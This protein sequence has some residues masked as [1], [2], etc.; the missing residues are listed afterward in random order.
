MRWPLQIPTV[1][2]PILSPLMRIALRR[3]LSRLVFFPFLTGKRPII[4][5]D[6]RGVGTLQLH[7]DEV[8]YSTLDG[9]VW[10]RNGRD[11]VVDLRV[12]L[13]YEHVSSMIPG[14]TRYLT[15]GMVR[16]PQ[17]VR[18]PVT[19]LSTYHAS[20]EKAT[21]EE[22]QSF[23]ADILETFGPDTLGLGVTPKRDEVGFIT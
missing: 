2:F 17:A 8:F 16:K 14:V 4:L 22:E 21:P 5:G 10:R 9:H 3:T 18:P 12:A 20:H 19:P 13:L 15:Q 11:F 7:S 1:R 23:N 6:T